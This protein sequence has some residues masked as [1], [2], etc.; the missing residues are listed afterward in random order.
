MTS[1]NQLL[2]LFAFIGLLGCEPDDKFTGVAAGARGRYVVT[3]YIVSGDTLFSLLP[4]ST[5]YKPGIN[6]IGITNF[7]IAIDV[8]EPDQLSIKTVYWRKGL[9]STFSKKVVV[10]LTN[11]NYQFSLIETNPPSAYEGSVGRFSGFFYERTLGGG[12]LIPLADSLTNSSQSPSQDV[13]IIAQPV[14]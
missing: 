11:Y 4:G 10:R 12:L 14:R 9:Q 7:T 5:G 3:A 2:L 6:K 8:I 1:I 13:V